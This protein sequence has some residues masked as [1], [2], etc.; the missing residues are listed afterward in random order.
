MEKYQKQVIFWVSIALALS[1]GSFLM[2]KTNQALNT[3]TTT[4]T[5]TFNGEGSVLAKPDVAVIDLSIVTEAA[6]SK[7]AQDDNS[8]KSRAVTEFLKKQ[9]VDEKDIKTTGYNIYPQYHYPRDG[10]PQI[11]GYQV[12]QTVQVKVRDLDKTDVVLDG[13][14]A[15]GAN[16]VNNFQLTIDEPDKL[17][18]EAREKAIKNAKEKADKLK[19][20]L[21]IDLGRIVNFYESSGGYYPVP[22]YKESSSAVDGR[23]GGGPSI[24][25]GENEISVS[26]SITYQ[27]K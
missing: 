8:A 10:K 17:Q 6:T 18:A 23:G 3:A 14:V 4:N 16:Q 5:V 13:I 24:P 21:G 1:F 7:A 19:K 11:S 9:D 12:N 2:V 27:I 15:A 25:T 26:V 20:Q 22:M